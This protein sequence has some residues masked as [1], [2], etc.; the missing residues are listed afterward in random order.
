MDFM[1]PERVRTLAATV[2]RFVDDEVLPVERIVLEK[3][4][5]AASGEIDRL[6]ARVR[7]MGLLAPHMP[8]AWGGGGM[9]FVGVRPRLRG[10][11][12]QRDRPLRL[13][14]PGAGR[15]E[16]GAA[17]PP[18]HRRAAG[19]LAAPPRRAARSGAASAMTEPEFPGSNPVWLGTD[20]PPRR[21]RLRDRRP[22]VVHLL[23][24]GRRLRDRDGGDRSRRARPHARASQILVPTDAPGFSIVRNIPVMGEAGEGWMSHAE[25]RLEGV[26][27]AGGE[28]HRRR[29][30][31]L[32]PR[33][34]AAGA[35]AHPPLHALDRHLRAGLRPALRAAR[36]RA[37]SR[38]ASRSGPPDRPGLDRGEPRR[39]RR[40]PPARAPHRL[41]HRP[42]GGAPRRG[43]TSR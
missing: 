12:A 22:Q 40:R 13:Q 17:P 16:H 9:A 4:F 18:R 1:I 34:G 28:P 11:R 31:G 6:R 19:A 14:L 30:G 7:E 23:G 39:D 43:T 20:R 8:E 26:P 35:G 36:P 25:V 10:A 42:R 21:R 24:R 15:G 5:G 27:R 37:S 3:G 2:R 41:A 29:G 33:P 38:R 32:R